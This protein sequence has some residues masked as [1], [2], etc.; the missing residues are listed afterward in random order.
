MLRLYE[1]VSP[2][3]LGTS[4]AEAKNPGEHQNDKMNPCTKNSGK[5]KIT[6][7]TSKEQSK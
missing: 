3:A 2:A 6:F 4:P 7:T 5:E 1:A